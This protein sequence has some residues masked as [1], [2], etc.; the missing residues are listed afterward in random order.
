[1]DRSTKGLWNAGRIVHVVARLFGRSRVDRSYDSHLNGQ[2]DGEAFR[3]YVDRRTQD[4]RAGRVPLDRLIP[5]D[6]LRRLAD[7]SD[8]SSG[9]VS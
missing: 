3:R 1:M 6:E 9:G 7:D 4:I 5:M 8:E 2:A